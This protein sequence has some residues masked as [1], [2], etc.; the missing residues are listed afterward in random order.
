VTCAFLPGFSYFKPAIPL[1]PL[2]RGAL[3]D[4]MSH[5]IPTAF[6]ANAGDVLILR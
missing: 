4:A 1:K 5:F 3:E 6:D 2:D